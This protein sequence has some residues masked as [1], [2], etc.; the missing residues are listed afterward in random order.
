MFLVFQLQE[1]SLRNRIAKYGSGLPLSPRG[2]LFD[3]EITR[4]IG[5]R[6]GG[7]FTY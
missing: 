5:S 6:Q 1:L 2:S 4:L 7:S 3:A